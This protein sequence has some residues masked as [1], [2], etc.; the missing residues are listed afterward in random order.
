MPTY[1]ITVEP[2]ASL[3]IGGYT[4]A[5]GESDADSAVDGRGSVIPGSAVKGALRESAWRIVNGVGRG[6]ELHAALFGNDEQE[7]V[8]RVGPL[9]AGRD[10]PGL[11]LRHHVSLERATRQAA[12]QRLFQNRVTGAGVGA[13]FQGRLSTSRP[14]GDEELGL[15]RAAVQITDQL[16]GGRGRGLGFV[17]VDLGEPESDAAPRFHVPEG[18]AAVGLVLEA[19]EPLNLGG[20]KDPGNYLAGKDVIDGSALRGAVAATLLRLGSSPAQ[21]EAIFGGTSPAAFRDARI[22]DGSGVPAPMTLRAPKA[23][24]APFDTAGRLCARALGVAVPAAEMKPSRV[25]DGTFVL[26]EGTWIAAAVSRRTI[27]RTARDIAGGHA[28]HGQLFSLEVVDPDPLPS[29]PDSD[30]RTKQPCHFFAQVS[31]TYEQLAAIVRAAESDL[32]VGGT[33][34]RG[35][36]R[37]VLRDMSVRESLPPLSKRHAAWAA[38]VRAMGAEDSESTAVLLALGPIAVEQ[39]RLLAALSSLGLALLDGVARRRT[40]GGWNGRGRIPRQLQGVFAPGS[41][42]VVKTTGQAS[43]LPPLEQL[44]SRGIGPGRPDGWGHLVA[45]HPIHVDCAVKEV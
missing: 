36:G 43:I 26:A 27:T 6:A 7:G 40:H 15:L 22:G 4:Q 35:F 30:L 24:G 11:V 31:G 3:F 18:S 16:G 2:H 20:P 17:S 8:L 38:H 21:M 39:S 32:F 13:R 41:V 1:Q 12:D 34:N 25:A 45:C 10:G 37:L 5:R 28:A 14:L 23:G 33:R 19:D 9:R 44:E 29:G 42:F